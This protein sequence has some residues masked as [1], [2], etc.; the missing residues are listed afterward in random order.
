M[1]LRIPRDI[2]DNPTPPQIFLCNTGKKILG[3]L[4][5]YDRNLDA[6]WGSYGELTFSIDRQYV[7]VLTGEIKVNPLFDKAEGLRKIY[8]RNVGYFIIQDPNTVYGDGDTKTLTCF[9]AEY[10]TTSKLLENFYVNT[11]EVDSIEVTYAEEKYGEGFDKTKLYEFAKIDEYSI[12]EK[13]YIQKYE[14]NDSFIFEQIQISDEITY[15]TYFGDGANAGFPLYKKRYPNVQ[16]HNPNRPE[17]SLL[18][19]IFKKIPEWSIGHVDATLWLKERTFNEERVSV[20][21][22]LMNNVQDTFR[23]VVEWDTIN[24]IVNFYEEA[25]D[26]IT[27]ENTVQTRFDTD[28]YISRENL[29]NEI[30]VR[31]SSD[32]IKTKLKVSGAEDLDIREV[33]L[34]SNYIMNLDFFHTVDWM[35]QDLYDAYQEYL[36]AVEEYTP[37]YTKVTQGRVG[38]YNRWNDL[39]N[40][41]PA[42][43]GVVLIGDKF[44]RLYCMY[45][46]Y[47]TVYYPT[48]LTNLVKDKSTIDNFYHLDTP[49]KLIDKTKLED[50]AI[51]STQ[52]FKFKYVKAN[53]NF[54]YIYD[55][56]LQSRQQLNK[57]LKNYNVDK[58]QT[59]TGIDDVLLKLTNKDSDVATFRVIDDP[60]N[61]SKY[62]YK[63]KLSIVNAKYGTTFTPK[64][65]SLDQWFKGE[66]TVDT[67]KNDDQQILKDYTV[68]Y[69]GTLGAYLVLEKDET[70]EN[71]VESYG[72]RLLREKHEV[73]TALFQTQ[74]E[75][76]FSEEKYQCIVSDSE[77]SPVNEGTRWLDTSS[78]PVVLKEYKSGWKIIN[79]EVP[80][81]EEY[82]YKNYVRYEDNYNKLVTIQKVLL[83]KEKEAQ[84]MLDG[85]EV[86]DVSVPIDTYE[87]EW[88]NMSEDNKAQYK[89]FEEFRQESYMRKA[90]EKYF[91]GFQ[92]VFPN[93]DYDPTIPLYPFTFDDIKYVVYMKGT[94]PYIAYENSINVWQIKMNYYAEQVRLENFFNEDQWARLSPMI[95]EDVF[96]D[97]NFLLTSYESEEERLEICKELK[98]AAEK[99]LKTLSQPSLEFTM[100]LANILALPEF[101]PL[102]DQFQLGNFVR[103]HIRDGLVKRARLLNVHINFE[104]LSDF[105]ADFGNLITTKSEIDKHAEL[106]QQAIQAGKQVAQASGDWQKAVDK[107]N[108]LEEAIANGL[109]DVTLEVGK[110]YGQNIEIGKY[111]IRGR[112][113]IDGTTDQ[114]EDEQFALINN[115]L[116]FTGD[117][118]KTSKAA[119]GKFTVD[120]KDRWGVLSDAVIAGYI[121]GST[122]KG[123]EISGGSLE[124]GGNGGKFK[125][126]ED[127]SVQILT[128][129]DQPIFATQG[130]ISDIKGDMGFIQDAR[131]FHTVLEYS[132]STIFSEPKRECIITCKVYSWDTDITSKVKE[133]ESTRFS[134]IRASTSSDDEWNEMHENQTSNQIT[135]TN[136]DIESNAQ[137]SCEVSFDDTNL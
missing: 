127:G 50:G 112:K 58:E 56:T 87:N 68:S 133:Q 104:D 32:D 53:N 13:Y 113:L 15:E 43:A 109:Q 93:K 57:K 78:S 1:Q 52:G 89:D 69:I 19:C 11:G 103:V 3:E 107:S 60:S 135:I 117:N 106:L 128:S 88:D 83:K 9:S 94:K 61:G 10:E 30:N 82:K 2:F 34:G 120:G 29:A 45:H 37:E 131:R 122:I 75:G 79:A 39:M 21:D 71:M 46:V 47:D 119:F 90:A 4:P 42:Q 114:Y 25:E 38:A 51:V 74:T 111:G 27:D 49:T 125:V 44:E 63:V 86:S 67:I 76:M 132:G 8:V 55:W 91:N 18:H 22:F 64:P 98:E 65:Y 41:I 31:Y 77:P 7:D 5:A 28:V 24:H 62:N 66:L 81:N 72:I 124:I 126:S 59:G 116:V 105:S 101:R 97:D 137:F 48:K 95:R 110:A 12:Y 6:K 23:C 123:T 99:E 70:N 134:W 129:D 100:N 73:Y 118:W 80:E 35:E 92:G 102:V 16:F 108:K 84:Y 115:K 96:V 121:E 17:L 36:D 54:L 85:Y 136:A 33:N 14:D 26:G 20:Y 40:A 130:D